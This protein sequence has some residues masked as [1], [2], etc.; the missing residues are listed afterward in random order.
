MD[1]TACLDLTEC[2]KCRTLVLFL[3]VLI[4]VPLGTLRLL[5]LLVLIGNVVAVSMNVTKRLG[6]CGA[7]GVP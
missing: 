5:S 2:L 7:C 4:L 6:T 3:R 1:L